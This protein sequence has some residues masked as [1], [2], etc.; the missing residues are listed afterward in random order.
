[1]ACGSCKK[2]GKRPLMKTDTDAVIESLCLYAGLEFAWYFQSGSFAPQWPLVVASA[3]YYYIRSQKIQLSKMWYLG[4]AAGAIGMM[5]VGMLAG[6][7]GDVMAILGFMGAVG[8]WAGL[9]ASQAVVAYV[10]K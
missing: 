2:P 10:N 3:G 1:M 7:S 5:A 6:Q 4:P 9:Y 8:A